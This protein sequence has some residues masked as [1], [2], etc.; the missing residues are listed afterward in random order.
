VAITTG[1]TIEEFEQLPE[2][3]ARNR[4]LV[5]GELVDVSGNNPHHNRLRDRLIALLLPF[6]D[7]GLGLVI[8]EQEFDFDGNAHG[9]DVSFL[10][11][12]KAR[13][14]DGGRRVQDFVPDLAVEIVSRRDTFNDL[15]EKAARYRRCGTQE[16]WVLIPSTR[17]AFV[18]SETRQEILREDQNFESPLIPGFSIRLGELFDRAG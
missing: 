14:L 2:A 5:N 6:E 11:A 7:K 12:P 8:G 3:L 10:A 4:E 15:M 17:Q 1:I 16:V 13:M 18:Q 9:P